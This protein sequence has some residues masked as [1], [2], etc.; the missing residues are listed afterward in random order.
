MSHAVVIDFEAIAIECRSICEVATKQLCQ[1]DA[2]LEKIDRTSQ[3]LQG[4]E[5]KGMKRQLTEHAMAIRAQIDE[6]VSQSDAVGER[7]KVAVARETNQRDIVTTAQALS[8]EVG[9]MTT[10]EIA[11]YE[12]LLD[13][14]LSRSIAEH[15][16]D[17]RLRASGTVAYN[18]EFSASLANIKDETL[19]GFIYLE[20]LEN[21]NFG[22][23]FEQLK[24]LA[25]N[26]LKDGVDN[27]FRKE[28]RT[29]ISSIE[30]EMR[31]AKL[32]EETIAA[33]VRSDAVDVNA[34]I[35]E[36]RQ[37]ATE[38]IVGETVRKKTLKVIMQCIENKGF[39]VDRSNIKMQPEKNEVIMVA[40]KIS[41][42]IAEFRVML[43]GK[44]I[45]HFDGYEGQA[46][47]EDIKPFMKDLEDIYGIKVTKSKE[48][49]SNPDKISTEKYQQMKTKKIGE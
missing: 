27:Y 2:L 17:M 42:E 12:A 35:A 10:D 41:G 14:L 23:S 45:Y 24:A 25:E 18:A 13:S 40:Q 19:K 28:R 1:I 30:S 36:I 43:D 4:E 15:N 34:Q 38:K 44:F 47:Q 3:S 8:R 20:W 9:R 22:K 5:T 37:K 39:I 26:N 32:D 6:I 49:W 29:I 21:K 31:N 46:C 11:R 33:V 48:I 7:G 16:R